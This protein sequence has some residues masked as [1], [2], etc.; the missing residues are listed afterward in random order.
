MIPHGI[1]RERGL[2]PGLALNEYL[3]RCAVG[4]KHAKTSKTLA[5][6]LEIPERTVRALIHELRCLGVP[7]A[8][9]VERPAGFYIPSDQAEADVCSRHLWARVTEIASVAR[10][11]DKSAERLGLRRERVEQ[12]SFVFGST[13]DEKDR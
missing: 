13:L 5:I 6:T 4:R 11:F 3:K 7:I 10:S 8:S 2:D 12:I 9:S 1:S